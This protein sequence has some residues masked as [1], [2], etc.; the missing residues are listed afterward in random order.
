MYQNKL[1]FDP[2]HLGGPTGVAKKV[3]MPMVHSAQTVHLCWAKINTISKRMLP[4]DPCHLKVP[5]GVPKMNFEPIA[6]SA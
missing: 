5:S 3:S 2:R 1:S 4:L 6:H